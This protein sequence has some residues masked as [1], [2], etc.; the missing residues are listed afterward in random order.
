[1]NAFAPLSDI[2]T[3]KVIVLA[4]ITAVTTITVAWINRSKAPKEPPARQPFLS[5]NLKIDRSD[6]RTINLRLDNPGAPA[7]VEDDLG[8]CP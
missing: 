7:K 1:M 3:T 5:L 6:R 4:V 2:E 8:R